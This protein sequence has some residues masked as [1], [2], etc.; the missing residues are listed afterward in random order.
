MEIKLKSTNKVV[1]L[2]T[3][4]GT[5]MPARIWKGRTAGRH[6]ASGKSVTCFVTRICATDCSEQELEEFHS[7]L[8]ARPSL[9]IPDKLR[10]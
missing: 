5:V 9:H 4:Q 10:I 7:E 3:E 2:E 1:E 8:Q 6:P